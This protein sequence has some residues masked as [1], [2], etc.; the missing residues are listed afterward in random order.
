ML[1]SNYKWARLMTCD[2]DR[3]T[4]LILVVILPVHANEFSLAFSMFSMR[5]ISATAVASE[6]VIVCK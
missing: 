3:M 2:K 1:P 4:N 6:A 5:P